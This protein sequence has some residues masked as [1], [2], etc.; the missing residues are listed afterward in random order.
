M[1]TGRAAG[2]VPSAALTSAAVT[3]AQ[4][5]LELGLGGGRPLAGSPPEA[6]APAVL[7]RG[8]GLGAPRSVRLAFLCHP[9][10]A[11]RT[12]RTPA[13][14]PRPHTRGPLLDGHPPRHSRP[15]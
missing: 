1:S 5:T 14:D 13:A 3:M 9:P 11:T 8:P 6:G 15:T 12:T 7:R 2:V 4:V 10:S